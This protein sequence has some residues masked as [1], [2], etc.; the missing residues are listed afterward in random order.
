MNK[1]SAKHFC[2]TGALDV[3]REVAREMV[4]GI[5]SVEFDPNPQKLAYNVGKRDGIEVGLIELIELI[6]NKARE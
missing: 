2:Q 4:E 6:N 1:E 5:P 3:L